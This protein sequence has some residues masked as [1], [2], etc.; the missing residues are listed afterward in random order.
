MM[1][2]FWMQIFA[3]GVCEELKEAHDSIVSICNEVKHVKSSFVMYKK[4]NEYD[5]IMQFFL[6]TPTRWNSTP[7]ILEA[8][9]NDLDYSSELSSANESSTSSTSSVCIFKFKR[10]QVGKDSLR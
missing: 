9:L 3:Q 2:V 8:L 10:N 1:G 6:D 4:L 5:L 7:L